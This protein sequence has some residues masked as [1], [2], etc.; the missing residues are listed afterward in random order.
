MTTHLGIHGS[1]ERIFPPSLLRSRLVDGDDAP[2]ADA[3]LTVSVV[4]DDFDGIDAL[5]TFGYDPAVL[6]SDVEWIHVVRAGYDEFPVETLRDDGISLTNSTGLHGASV[7]ETTVGY[8]LQFARGLHRYR[9]DQ[10]EKEW[11]P[12]AWDETF[13]LEGE[14]VCVVGLGTLGRG[15]ARRADALGMSVVGVRRTPTPVDHV[16]TR[17]GPADLHEAVEDARFVVLAVP[18]TDDTEGMFGAVE[19]D[20]MREDAYLVNV[21]RGPVADQSAL[22][23]A[24]RDDAIAGAALDVFEEEP[25]PEE[26]PLWAFENVVVT[27][28]ASAARSDYPDRIAELVGE[29]VRRF[30]RGESLA[31]QVV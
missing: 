5:V 25:L 23:S 9:S 18:L 20:A 31:N 26:S 4:D 16:E 29:N 10:R 14:T 8:F 28:H 19:L 15:I 11:N 12:P 7:G 13:T 27:P 21:A 2:D 6:D 3:D 24:L 22:V 17:Y 30:E 1:V